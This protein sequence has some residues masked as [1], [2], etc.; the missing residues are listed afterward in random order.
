MTPNDY[1]T[2]TYVYNSCIIIIHITLYRN[3]LNFDTVLTVFGENST[4]YDK[5]CINTIHYNNY[6]YSIINIQY[7][8]FG[9]VKRLIIGDNLYGEIGEN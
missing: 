3:I 5:T 1:Q 6:V 4:H 7:K 8:N 9:T 2:C